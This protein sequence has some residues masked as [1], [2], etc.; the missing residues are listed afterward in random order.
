[1][2]TIYRYHKSYHESPCN[3]WAVG[4]LEKLAE[5]AAAGGNASISKTIAARASTLRD[6]MLKTMWDAKTG[7]FC[8]GICADPHVAGHGSVYTDLAA[9][10]NG[11]VP[12][13]A[14]KGVWEKVVARGIEDIGAYGAYL[15]F[16]AVAQY[17]A[18]DDGTAVLHALTKCDFTSWC[19]EYTM[20]DATMTMEAFPVGAGNGNSFSH[21][22][23]TSAITGIVNNLIGITATK[24]GFAAFAV[25]PKLGSL[26]HATVLVPTLHGFINVTASPGRL[27]VNVPCNTAAR[28]CVMLPQSPP[29]SAAAVSAAMNDGGGRGD[30]GGGRGHVQVR[31]NF[32][33]QIDGAVVEHVL[34]G[35]HLCGAAPIGCGPRGAARV[36]TFV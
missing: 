19:A 9:L 28:V 16:V 21:L 4:G 1:M 30:D 8:D 15:Y 3:A 25:K 23:G 18:G 29:G 10:F 26:K 14:V 32:G 34:E 20:W 13:A 17:P 33:L 31:K 2:P 36:L 7:R 22:W 5:I 6:S 12:A 24:P 27:A 35:M 11:V